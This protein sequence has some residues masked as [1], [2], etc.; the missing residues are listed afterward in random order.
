[1]CCS[2]VKHF[3]GVA[4]GVECYFVRKRNLRQ[5]IRPAS[6]SW[7]SLEALA[8]IVVCNHYGAGVGICGVA[9]NMIAVDMGV[10]DEIDRSASDVCDRFNQRSGNGFDTVIDKNDLVVADKL[11]PAK[12][13]APS[14]R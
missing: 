4:T 13:S 14:I 11:P 7:V 8:D 12:P 2:Y 6:F 1:M 3:C 9:A 10:Y 5:T